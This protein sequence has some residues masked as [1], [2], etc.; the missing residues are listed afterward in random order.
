MIVMSLNLLEGLNEQQYQAVVS[1]S[2]VIRCL[3]GAGTGKTRVLTHRIAHLNAKY[4][5]GTSNMMAL[6]FTR[7]AGKE[8]KER[9]MQLVGEK[10]GRQLFC[11]TFHAF[12]VKVLKEYGH[13]IGLERNFMIYDQSDRESIIQRIIAEFHYDTSIKKVL[14]Y[15][16]HPTRD[17]RE[18]DEVKVLQELDYRMR[19]NNAV[20]LD[21]L[22]SKTLELLTHHEDIC[23]DYRQQYKYIFIDEFQD[24]S[25]SQLEMIQCIHPENLFV[26]GDDFQAIYGWRGA[27]VKHII[28]FPSKFPKCETVILKQN[29]RSTKPIVDASNSLIKHNVNQTKKELI[30]H[31]E[32]DPVKIIG[33]NDIKAEAQHIVSY[34]RSKGAP[35]ANHAILARTNRQIDVMAEALRE[36]DLPSLVLSNRGDPLKDNTVQSVLGFLELIINDRKSWKIKRIINF[37]EPV[38]TPLQMEEVELKGLQDDLSFVDTLK[39]IRGKIPA[40]DRFLNMIAGLQQSNIY[41]MDAKDAFRELVLALHLIPKL[42][43]KGLDNR[44]EK[45]EMAR[46]KIDT[47]CQVQ[48]KLGESDRPDTFL[49]WVVTKDIQEKLM[50]DMD[51]VKLMTVHG[52]KGLEF[53]TV[54]IVG[55]NED[56]FPSGRGDIEEERRLMYVAV[57]RAK[58]KLIITRP[59]LSETYSGQ[60]IET[61]PSRFLKELS[62]RDE[63]YAMDAI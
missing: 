38:L 34:V 29:Y 53:H 36:A 32:G 41:E 8:M 46:D 9:I 6:T 44:I 24:T 2:P 47:W 23:S 31:V 18:T 48:R 52:S 61:K 17:K 5:I 1:D 62:I 49:R 26:V 13:R 37:P 33:V 14:N 15:L 25:D 40:V 4:R 57:T 16:A 12:C 22:L 50:E 35:Y 63:S 28:E 3:A 58:K 20:D 19:Q 39:T 45:L 21:G 42:R 59:L 7:L 54:S 55:L 11:N 60:L 27:E 56:S 30:N 51:A 10:E 43:D